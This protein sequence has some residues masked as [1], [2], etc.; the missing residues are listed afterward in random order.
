MTN[1]QKCKKKKRENAKIAKN[2]EKNITQMKPETGI[3][4]FCVIIF[5]PIR[6]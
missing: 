4:V 1:M 5:E 3:F 2:P 6:I